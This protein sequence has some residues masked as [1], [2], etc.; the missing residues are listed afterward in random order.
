VRLPRDIT[1]GAASRRALLA[2]LVAAIALA[3]VAITAAAGIGVVGFTALL[4]FLALL[5]WFGV[6]AGVRLLLRKR[7]EKGN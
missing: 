3:L 2:D 6:E 4:V 7:P 1:A 5:V